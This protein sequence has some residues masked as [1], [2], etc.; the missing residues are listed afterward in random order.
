MYCLAQFIKTPGSVFLR[1]HYRST[2]RN[3]YKQVYQQI[4]QHA[5]TAAY[6]CKGF[7]SYK[8]ANNN[9]I[10]RIVQLLKK[11]SKQNGEEKVQQLL[12]NY[13]LGYAVGRWLGDRFCHENKLLF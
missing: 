6:G 10:R 12:P 3:A 5:G 1:Y 2:G 4:D 7:F 11:C 9:G 13:A 8:P